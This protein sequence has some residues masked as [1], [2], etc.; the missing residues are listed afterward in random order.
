MRIEDLQPG[1][2]QEEQADRPDPVGDAGPGELAIDQRRGLG[3]RGVA[4]ASHCV[5]EPKPPSNVQRCYAVVAIGVTQCTVRGCAGFRERVVKRRDSSSHAG[6]RNCL[7]HDASETA[8][9]TAAAT[10]TVLKKNETT[11]WT[12]LN[13]RMAVVVIAT[14]DV[15][16]VIPVTKEKYR[17]SNAPGSVPPGKSSPPCALPWPS[18]HPSGANRDARSGG[19]PWCGS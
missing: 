5:H 8:T 1:Q 15:C 2:Q 4:L 16:A 13:L 6:D 7:A 9:F 17:K 10:S 3:L 11:E 14:S 18:P 19:P 12:R